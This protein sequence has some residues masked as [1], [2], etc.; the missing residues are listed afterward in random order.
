MGINRIVLMMDERDWDYAS[1]QDKAW[2]KQRFLEKMDKIGLGPELLAEFPYFMVWDFERINFFTEEA[3]Q[4]F[5][6]HCEKVLYIEDLCY[7]DIKE[8]DIQPEIVQP[9]RPFWI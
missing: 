5:Y 8:L 3:R 9:P 6:Q 7:L 2:N 4:I 1:G